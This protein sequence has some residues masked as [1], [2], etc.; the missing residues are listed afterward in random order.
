M[1]MECV[2]N[3]ISKV[4]YHLCNYEDKNLPLLFSLF[5]NERG[6][7]TLSFDQYFPRWCI[8]LL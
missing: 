3:R 5:K 8:E 4:I 2:A 1:K 6:I 7:K